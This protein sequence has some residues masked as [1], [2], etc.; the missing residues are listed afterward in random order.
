M[1]RRATEYDDL[2]SDTS[3]DASNADT[4][5]GTLHLVPQSEQLANPDAVVLT[6]R[7]SHGELLSEFAC[8]VEGLSTGDGDRFTR[9]IWEQ[10]EVSGPWVLFQG[11]P[12]HTL[13]FGGRETALY[14]Q[15]GLGALSMFDGARVQGQSAWG[16]DGV[17]VGQMSQLKC[18]M[19]TGEVHDKITGAI[20]PKQ[21]DHLP[22]IWAFCESP[23]Y[24]SS[25]RKINTKLNVAT[26]TLVKVPFDLSY[27]QRVA[28]EKYPNGLPEPQSDDP[29]QWLFHGHPAGR[30]PL[31]P[32]PSPYLGS[33]LQVA[34]TRLLGYRWPAELDDEMRLAPEARAWVDRCKSLHQFVDDDGVVPLVPINK[35]QPGAERVRLLLEAAF[36]SKWSPGLLN[37]LLAAA[38]SPGKSLDEWIK[39]DFFGQHCALFHHRPFIWQ[40]WDGRKDGFNIL[41]HYH[42]LAE[43]DGRGKRLLEKII[44]TYLGDWITQQKAASK[45]GVPGADSRE[46]AAQDLQK[47]LELIIAGEPPHDIF[48]RWKPLRGQP[49]GWNPDI[50]DGV[51]MNI[52]PFVTAGVLRGKVNV[53]WTKDRGKE[54]QSIRP[55]E[56]FPWF[57]SCPEA[58]PPID[59]AG[60]KEFTGERFNDLHYT[61][62][63]KQEAR[64]K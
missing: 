28:A 63:R 49:I 40:V 52:R 12:P 13:R 6:F 36:G 35:E 31:T 53:K 57:W 47:K 18:A 51:R 32:D 11:P 27:W 21:P 19:Y 24:N 29:T 60:G 23:E 9:C 55:R 50:N 1:T 59:F 25:I 20:V 17:I 45:Q 56:Q 4:A 15:D 46:K 22:A 48:L 33:V 2:Q 41:I 61:N 54:P 8:V 26:A 42:R 3:E 14:W 64:E 62:A 58:N 5:D 37:D 39:H 10:A 43:G 44:Y 34:V 30:V 38:G 7:A 16:S